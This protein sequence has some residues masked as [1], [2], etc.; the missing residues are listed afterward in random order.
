IAD[1]AYPFADNFYAITVSNRPPA[2]AAARERADNTAALIDWILS[3][4]GQELV[5]KTGYVP[6]HS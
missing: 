6:L 3:V 1:G 2:T 4:P 5:E